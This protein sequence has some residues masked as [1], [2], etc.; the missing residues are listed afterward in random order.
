VTRIWSVLE[1]VGEVSATALCQDD[2]QRRFKD[3]KLLLEFE[4]PRA[5]QIRRLAFHARSDDRRRNARLQLSDELLSNVRLYLEGQEP[6]VSHLKDE[7][8]DILDGSKAW[9]SAISRV[10]S[11]LVVPLLLAFTLVVLTAMLPDR[12]QP[13]PAVSFGRAVFMATFVVTAF[14]AVGALAWL[15]NRVRN[16]YFPLATFALGQGNHRHS[17]NEKVRWC[18]IVCFAVSVLAS[19]TA[20][21][22]LWG[23]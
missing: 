10:E 17:H 15:L 1:G 16:R 4:N 6:A 22:I 21:A 23:L 11:W 3:G 7:L 12:Q 20:A 13:H 9:Y 19:L 18:V 5:K 2:T 14:V 8:T